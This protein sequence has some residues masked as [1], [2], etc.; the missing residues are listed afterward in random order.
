MELSDLAVFRTVVE[1]GGITKA[2]GRLNRVQSNITTRMKKLE[3]DLGVALFCRHGRGVKL[4]PAG[5]VLL[6]YAQRMLEL[7]DEAREAV[8]GGTLTGNLRLGTMASTAAVRLPVPLA[9]FHR[10]YPDITLELRTGASYP[11]ISQVLQGELDVALVAEPVEDPRLETRAVYV[12]DLVV[13][14]PPGASAPDGKR[15]TLLTFVQG[16]AYRKH[17]EDWVTA[18]GVIPDRIVEM[19]SYHGMLGCVAAGMGIALVPASLLESHP[20]RSSLSLLPLGPEGRI[21]TLLVWRKAAS[22]ARIDA[23]AEILMTVL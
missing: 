13:V 17:L 16:C 3:E 10:R 11:L 22:R 15:L 12:E 2:A 19:T 5:M 20:G 1:A 14:M 18:R 23:L 6:T 9:A 7:A 8:R 4:A 21:R